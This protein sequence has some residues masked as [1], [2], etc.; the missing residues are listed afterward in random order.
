MA[1][2]VVSIA[3]L[4]L[5]VE[6]ITHLREQPPPPPPAVRLSLTAPPGTELGVGDEPLDAA[7]S[8]DQREVVFVATQIRRSLINLAPG[9][10]TQLWRRRLDAE[11][12]E[13]IAGTAGARLPAWKQTGNVLSFFADAQLKL[14]DLKTGAITIVSDAADPAGATW[15]RDGSLLFVPNSGV[16]RR[17]LDGKTTDATRLASGDIAHAY[18]VAAAPGTRFTYIAVRDDGRRVVRLSENGQERDLGT[19]TAHAAFLAGDR[20]VLLFVK[21][22]TLLADERE[23]DTGRMA[24]RDLPIALEVGVT[25]S[26]RGLF[27]ASPDV[28][29]HSAAVERPR[30][31]TWLSMDGTRAG[32]VADVGDYWQ[33]R[34]SPDDTRLAVTARDPLL[35][36]LDVLMVP[37]LGTASSQ[38]LTASLAADT[39]PVWSPDGRRITF[40]SAQRGRPELLVTPSAISQGS[41]DQNPA[42]PLK[43]TGEVPNDWRGSELLVQRR[44]G[45]GFDLVRA[46]ESSGAAVSVAETPF[47]ETEGRWS[48]DGRW[49]AYVSDEPG[50]PDVFVQRG[51][52]RQRLSL[53]GGTRPRWTR[54]SR[55]LLFLRG[56][57]VLRADLNAEGTRF[58]S[59]R[60]LFEAPGIRDF[61]VAHRSDRLLALLPVQIEP[62]SSISV[63]LNWRSLLVEGR[64]RPRGRRERIAPVL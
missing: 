56:S 59:P 50:R 24:G 16:V 7:I 19:T 42:Q 15:L 60:P 14:L 13:P 28:L 43:A 32:T 63:I 48:P 39:D 41:S 40:R 22:D 2:F 46:D 23:P 11:K 29:I 10:T 52:T 37:A 38:R 6:T 8:P 3:V 35:R 49:I 58:G 62:V 54:D 61:D 51:S 31:L 1:G 34:I 9:G 57:T 4:G 55:A 44:G 18:P 45:A 33:V 21:D 47:N 17:L 20:D 64:Q 27:T 25:R 5:L 36:S 26:G 30:Q 12:S 53:A